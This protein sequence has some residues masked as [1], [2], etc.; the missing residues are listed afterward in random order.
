MRGIQYSIPATIPAFYLD[1]SAPQRT[2]ADESVSKTGNISEKTDD[3]G[4]WRTTIIVINHQQHFAIN[5]LIY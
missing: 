5:L 4:Q 1:V 3:A 2:I